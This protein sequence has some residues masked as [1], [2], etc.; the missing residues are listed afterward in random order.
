MSPAVLRGCLA[1][2]VPAAVLL[3]ALAAPHD[4]TA[5]V[6]TPYAPAA[7]G[8][9]LGADAL[10]RDVLSR[11]LA[12]G[13]ELTLVA[14]L[15]AAFA[16][17]LG[18]AAGL[19]AGWAA[20]RSGW[21][22]TGVADA[23]L[24]TPPLLVALVLAVSLPGDAAVVAATV[25]GG[26]P[27]TLRVVGDA[28]RGALDAGYVEAARG[29]G[30]RAPALLSREVLPALAGLVAADAGARFVT[31][32]QLATALGLLGFGAQ[33]PDPDWALMIR[34]N[35]PGAGLNPAGLIAPALA[36]AFVALAVAVLAGGTSA[37]ARTGPT[38]AGRRAWRRPLGAAR[39]RPRPGGRAVGAPT[40]GAPT[41]AAPLP[42]PAETPRETADGE[43]PD[44][45][46]LSVEGLTVTDRRG[47]R[48]LDGVSLCAGP[49][50]VVAVVGPSGCGKS[51]LLRAVLDALP[52]GLRRTAGTVR[53]HGGT[54]PPGRPARRWR[55]RTVGVVGQQPAAALHPLRRVP[56][57]IADGR[58]PGDMAVRGALTRLGLDPAALWRRYPGQLSGGQAQRVA[59]A[60][61]LM[62]DPPLLVLDEPTT[63]LDP[64]ALDLVVAAVEARRGDA[65]SVT[66][67]VSHD[68]EFVHRIGDRVVHLGTAAPAGRSIRPGPGAPSAPAAQPAVP[69][70]T[71][72]EAK[73]AV[74]SADGLR[75]VSPTGQLLLD[76]G[77]F[78]IRAGELVAITG[79]SGCG[80][81]TLLRALAGLRPPAAGQLRSHGEPLSWSVEDRR[82]ARVSAVQ[83]V[84][85]DP[86]TALNP[87][88]R[89]G[90]SIARPGR[91]LRGL[92]PSAAQ[93]LAAGLL[94]AVGLDSG[95]ARSRPTQLSGGQ[96]QRAAVA[97]ALAA[98][99]GVLA[100]DEIT[101][102]LDP[103]AAHGVLDLLGALC[104]DGLAVLLVTHDQDI[105][106][107]AD[108]VLRFDRNALIP[109]GQYR[110]EHHH[111]G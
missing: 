101:S 87:A 63:G 71:V 45:A 65:R 14:L 107:R 74:L 104:A 53:W 93:D 46:L 3:G 28:T 34:E 75:L 54:V 79:P 41:G 97:R 19:L 32:L 66:I 70:G 15:A 23:L 27:L 86:A 94:T 103:D 1:L 67:V 50:E 98:G 8:L 72:G 77:T 62:G 58:R 49:G 25:C 91:L 39:R 6:A 42:S 60:R 96:R 38:T 51:T 36:L 90:T 99:P 20:R 55:H 40:T 22:L 5:M 30:E 43:R 10:G 88:H 81:S 92:S 37:R 13:R 18:V 84:A 61:A 12:G 73:A 83:L 64:D 109:G 56:A 76:N 21:L 57:V 85:Q 48:L 9:S 31:A 68:A 2:A 26:A 52:D 7:P 24:A 4:P 17:L 80:K 95:V 110:T 16:T 33:P 59:L 108:R 102:A 100:A 111:A 82:P 78:E 89:V 11:L 44:G 69:A 29:R 47:R 35:L 105:A 106:Q